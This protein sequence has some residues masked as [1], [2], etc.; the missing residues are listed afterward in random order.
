MNHPS[1]RPPAGADVRNWLVAH[2]G[3]PDRYPE[4]SLEGIQAV[5]EAGARWIEFD[6]QMTADGQL[7]VVHD[8]DLSRLSG[9]PLR[10]TESTAAELEAVRT[11][12]TTGVTAAIPRLDQVLA[13][14]AQYPQAQAFVEL[15]RQSIRRHRLETAVDALLEHLENHLEQ[16]VFISFNWRA[17]RRASLHAS[18]PVGWVFKPWSPPARWLADKLQPDYLL[19]RADRIPKGAQPFWPGPWRW[20]IYEVD[21]LD[22]ARALRARGADLI[23]VDDLP[24]LLARD[25][26]NS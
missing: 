5:L 17:V 1:Q 14:L 22:Q 11:R 25:R 15:K 12:S 3:W 23:E 8:D 2:R 7:L 19:V 26:T 9:K 21:G 13:L 20:V 18:L 10:V 6:V 24:D 4:N 16:V